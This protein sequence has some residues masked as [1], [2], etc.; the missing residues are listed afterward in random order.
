MY[1]IRIMHLTY[2]RTQNRLGHDDRRPLHRSF[3]EQYALPAVL[4]VICRSALC[5]YSIG[6]AGFTRVFSG[7]ETEAQLGC[8]IE[9]EYWGNGFATEAARLAVA[10][11]FGN[12]KLDR[13]RASCAEENTASERLMKR[14]GMT[15]DPATEQ[16]GRREYVLLRSR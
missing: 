4:Q 11:A 8:F 3:L 16:R 1:I 10:Y 14:L 13:V 7:T 2:G 5:A 9:P 12:L 6:D 15:G